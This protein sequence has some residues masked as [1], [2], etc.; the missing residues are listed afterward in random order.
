[1]ILIDVAAPC[2]LY[3]DSTVFDNQWGWF[4]L[5]PL[6]SETVLFLRNFK[7]RTEGS[8]GGYATRHMVFYG[9]WTEASWSSLYDI[10]VQFHHL[11]TLVF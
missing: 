7:L 3:I 6:S 2:L 5:L 4:G 10:L 8:T 1:M 9:C 11:E